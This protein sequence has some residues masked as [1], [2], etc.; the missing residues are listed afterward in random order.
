MH[1]IQNLGL[2]LESVS[3]SLGEQASVRIYM[4][5]ITARRSRIFSATATTTT[6]S[7]AHTATTTTTTT[8]TTKNYYYSTTATTTTTTTTPY[9]S[10][11]SNS[12]MYIY[13][14]RLQST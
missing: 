13:I 12:I 5:P 6:T 8:T 11:Y 3:G 9:G 10:M 14:Y 1:P 7:A 2:F 4:C